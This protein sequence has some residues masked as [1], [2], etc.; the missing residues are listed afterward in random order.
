MTASARLDRQVLHHIG[1]VSGNETLHRTDEVAG[2][3]S[4]SDHSRSER[5]EPDDDDW[6]SLELGARTRTRAV[7]QEESGEF[8]VGKI[9]KVRTHTVHGVQYRV[10][11]CGYNHTHNRWVRPVDCEISELIV[12]FKALVMSRGDPPAE[13]TKDAQ[14]EQF[15]YAERPEVVQNVNRTHHLPPSAGASKANQQGTGSRSVAAWGAR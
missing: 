7:P 1:E 10:R 11:F 8:E 4:R 6:R 9:L 12:A 13:C 14:A 2:N 3:E 15:Y 5:D